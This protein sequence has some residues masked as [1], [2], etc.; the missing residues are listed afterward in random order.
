MEG[1]SME[2]LWRCQRLVSTLLV[3]DSILPALCLTP[4]RILHLLILFNKYKGDTHPALLLGRL[5]PIFY[6]QL[7]L[8]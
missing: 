8:H 3:L 7:P 6:V 4:G 2:E 1:D 5:S